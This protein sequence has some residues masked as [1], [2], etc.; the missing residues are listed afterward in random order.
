MNEY[1]FSS[2]S[3]SLAKSIEFFWAFAILTPSTI[4]KLSSAISFPPKV[5]YLVLYL[6]FHH[7][8]IVSAG[9]NDRSFFFYSISSAFRRSKASEHLELFE[10]EP[11]PFKSVT[12][13]S[14]V[15]ERY[16]I[17]GAGSTTNTRCMIEIR[18]TS[19][20]DEKLNMTDARRNLRCIRNASISHFLWSILSIEKR[21]KRLLRSNSKSK[22]AFFLS[23]RQA[24][25]T[26]PSDCNSTKFRLKPTIEL[27]QRREEKELFVWL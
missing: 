25:G 27:I 23:R 14:R 3:R 15:L 16:R 17:D 24:K 4:P 10:K 7:E 11:T 26:F 12:R 22:T 6:N 20:S 9:L 1:T 18:P 19:K 21:R 2:I 13:S 8:R 5:S